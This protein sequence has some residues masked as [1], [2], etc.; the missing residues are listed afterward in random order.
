MRRALLL[1]VV[2]FLTISCNLSNDC[3]ACFTPPRQ[4]NFNLVDATT[5]EDLF[6]NETFTEDSLKV[7]DELGEEVTFE[8]VFYNDQYIISLNEI[9]WELEPKI[10]TIELSSEISVIFE[11]DMDE[12]TSDCCTYFEVKVFNI[13]DYEYEEQYPSGIIQVKIDLN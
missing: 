2:L 7:F 12:V 10:Y 3:G 9:G 13:V 8:L 1:I 11:L 5:L 4:F 6:S